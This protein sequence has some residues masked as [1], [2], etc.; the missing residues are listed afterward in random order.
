[1]VAKVRV[2]ENVRGAIATIE[3]VSH[4]IVHR[5]ANGAFQ[6]LYAAVPKQVRHG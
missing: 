3:S 2:T 4:F 6:L 1:V 5:D